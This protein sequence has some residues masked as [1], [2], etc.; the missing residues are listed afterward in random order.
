MTQTADKKEAQELDI[1]RAFNEKPKKG[2]AMLGEGVSPQIVAR[3]LFEKRDLLD[4]TKIGEYLGEP[5]D[6]N[7]KVL[8]QHAKES[9]GTQ[10]DYLVGLRGYLDS[11]KL[12]GESQKIDRIMEAFAK[13]YTNANPEFAKAFKEAD[14]TKD[15]HD[16]AYILAFSTIMLN[17]TL[18][19]PNASKSISL[20]Q[21][22]FVSMNRDSKIDTKL[23][24][25]LYKSIASEEFKL[26]GEVKKPSVTLNV[27]ALKGKYVTKI[28]GLEGFVQSGPLVDKDRKSKISFTNT[29]T[30]ESVDLVTFQDKKSKKWVTS[31]EPSCDGAGIPHKESLKVA[32]LIANALGAGAG[33]VT[34]NNKAVENVL[35]TIENHRELERLLEKGK[36]GKLSKTQQFETAMSKFDPVNSKS[37]DSIAKLLKAAEAIIAQELA[38]AGQAASTVVGKIGAIIQESANLPNPMSKEEIA[39]FKKLAKEFPA[40]LKNGEYKL[41]DLQN[42]T[43]S[44]NVKSQSID[45]AKKYAEK[46]IEKVGPKVDLNAFHKE[47]LRMSEASS[48]DSTTSIEQQAANLGRSISGSVVSSSRDLVTQADHRTP[49]DL[50]DL[51]QIAETVVAEASKAHRD[52]ELRQKN[53][54]AASPKSLLKRFFSER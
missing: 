52:N 32:G 25:D 1:I 9:V 30:K 28:D 19:N 20:S 53:K 18:H 5:D 16:P 12:P 10:K 35:Q 36:I 11:F 47:L 17:T 54:T 23:L 15:E 43:A 4:K 46:G 38:V 14:P 3:F 33:K 49:R 39:E 44:I 40:K 7:L 13:T 31:I 21:E 6:F 37:Q 26:P 45:A 8:A 27:E 29:T 48:S 42:I 24:E 50:R 34:A 51:L 22:Q 2:I 41:E